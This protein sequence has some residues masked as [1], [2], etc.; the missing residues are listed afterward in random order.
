MEFWAHFLPFQ[1]SL[2]LAMAIW[3]ECKPTHEYTI[4]IQAR[5][6]CSSPSFAEDTEKLGFGSGTYS[7]KAESLMDL[8]ISVDSSLGTFTGCYELK[9]VSL[10]LSK[11]LLKKST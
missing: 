8:G 11:L 3:P 6:S 10:R 5:N 2:R 7:G 1:L 9:V 4:Q